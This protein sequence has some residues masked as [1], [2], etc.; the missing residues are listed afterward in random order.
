MSQEREKALAIQLDDGR[1]VVATPKPEDQERLAKLDKEI[2]FLTAKEGYDVAG[3]GYGDLLELDVE[4]HAITLRLPSPSDAEAVRRALAV[5]AV[6]ATIVA[7][8]AIAALQGT[9]AP[10]MPQPAAPPI[11]TEA[12]PM[13]NPHAAPEFGDRVQPRAP[14]VS[15]D[16]TLMDPHA[17]PE[18]GDRIAPAAPAAPAVNSDTLLMDPHAAP[19]FGDRIA[20]A[21]PA[22][23]NPLPV[24]KPSSNFL[25]E[26][27]KAS[28]EMTGGGSVSDLPVQDEETKY[29]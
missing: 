7:A 5:G 4:G 19:E 28:Q 3:H 23:A 14:S 12:Q 22:Q 29:K 16:S 6:T 9:Q 25:D 13:I 10:A 1:V 24:Q 26:K 8:G 27:D 20:P 2:V 11:V 15:T 17:A 21:A 18:F